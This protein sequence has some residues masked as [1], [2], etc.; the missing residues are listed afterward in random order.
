MNKSQ[1]FIGYKCHFRA[2]HKLLFDKSK[3]TEQ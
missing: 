1:N 3:E 2:K